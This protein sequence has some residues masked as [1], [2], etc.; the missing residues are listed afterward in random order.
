MTQL[1]VNDWKS[2]DS[3]LTDALDCGVVREVVVSVSDWEGDHDPIKT[4]HAVKVALA[5]LVTRLPNAVQ[6]VKRLSVKRF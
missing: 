3:I 5:K 1:K 4:K 2:L 6:N